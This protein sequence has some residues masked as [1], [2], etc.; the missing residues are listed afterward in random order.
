[1]VLVAPLICV[2]L[3]PQTRLGR[4]RLLQ[5]VILSTLTVILQIITMREVTLVRL[6]IIAALFQYSSCNSVRSSPNDGRA[7]DFLS[8]L[9]SFRSNILSL[10]GNTF[11][12]NKLVRPPLQPPPPPPPPAPV[13]PATFH[14]AQARPP[15]TS[16]SSSPQLSSQFNS[17][18]PQPPSFPLLSPSPIVEV[19]PPQQSQQLTQAKPPTI[20]GGPV[21]FVDSERLNAGSEFLNEIDDGGVVHIPKELWREDIGKIEH[22]LKVHKKKKVEGSFETHNLY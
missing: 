20:H 6:V 22:K 10:L 4:G 5:T 18:P 16:F 8:S 7:F 15:F 21:S 12:Q 3:Q 9:S 2:Q 13:R 19:H 14:H 17:A 1:M 11:N